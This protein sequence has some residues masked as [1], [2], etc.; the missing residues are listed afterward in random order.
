MLRFL[1]KNG[2]VF[3]EAGNASLKDV[4]VSD[5]II[6][7]I[8]KI[9]NAEG[10]YI[11]D[12]EENYILPGFI[13]MNC[14]VCDPGYENKENIM[15]VSRSA[16]KGGF[17][18]I[19][20]QPNTLPVVDNQTVVSYINTKSKKFSEIN[21]F[22]YGSMTEGCDGTKM[23]EIG[24]MQKAGIIGISDGG[25]PI[26]D[27]SLMRNIFMYSKMF[28]M[29]VITMC[30]DGFLS[31]KGVMN[32]GKVSTS[33]GLIGIP[34]EAEEIIVARNLIL[35]EHVGSKLHISHVSTSG[36]VEL[37]RH[38]KARGV[39]VTCETQP[40][41][42]TLTEED[43]KGYNTFN[44]V[45]PPL[46]THEDVEAIKQGLVD[47]TIDV[48]STGH[49]PD[50]IESKQVEFDVASYGISALETTFPISYKYLVEAGYLTFFELVKKLSFN[51]AGILN[52]KDKGLIKKNYDADIVIVDIKKPYTIDPSSFASRAKYSPYK[53]YEVRGNVVYNFVGGHVVYL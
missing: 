22:I 13:D 35:A 39:N 15:S 3:D 17:S 36:S 43:V 47:G 48:I 10:Y 46:R 49:S 9:K 41:Y 20:V 33:L 1:I 2:Y 31:D 26:T 38:A 25:A 21:L 32:S 51:P 27:T 28:D 50:T 19:T 30:K 6:M 29:P 53:G 4:L 40:H 52:L 45:M 8:G 16:S 11:I 24:K 23:S 42:F 37:I 34:R 5:G 12:A 44:K 14:N 7:E 18:S